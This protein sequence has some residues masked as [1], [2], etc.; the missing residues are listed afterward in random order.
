MS[1]QIVI[2]ELGGDK[3][4]GASLGDRYVV[5]EIDDDGGESMGAFFKTLTEAK[6]DAGP[7]A[8]FWDDNSEGWRVN[9]ETK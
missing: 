5:Q 1:S 6:K 4:S 8:Y 2:T 7:F 3:V 9:H